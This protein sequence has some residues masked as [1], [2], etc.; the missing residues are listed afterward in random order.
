MLQHALQIKIKIQTLG[1]RSITSCTEN[2]LGGHQRIK[3][4]QGEEQQVH[5][6]LHLRYR[7]TG[8]SFSS[9]ILCVL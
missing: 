3:T 8:I 5:T 6:I 2:P 9:V 1:Y 7:Y 4:W